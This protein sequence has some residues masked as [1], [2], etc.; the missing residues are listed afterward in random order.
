MNAKTAVLYTALLVAMI[1]CNKS[2][3]DSAADSKQA[4]EVIQPLRTRQ[5][6]STTFRRSRKP[7]LNNQAALGSKGRFSWA[8]MSSIPSRCPR[9]SWARTGKVSRSAPQ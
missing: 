4:P 5:R 6:N 7:R 3:T 2:S 8:K 1:G 9:D